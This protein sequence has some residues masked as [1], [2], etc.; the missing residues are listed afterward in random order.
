MQVRNLT[1]INFTDSLRIGFES[2]VDI[3]KTVHFLLNIRSLRITITATKRQLL[4][5]GSSGI[6]PFQKI[7][8]SLYLSLVSPARFISAIRNASKFTDQDRL[9]AIKK[10][11]RKSKSG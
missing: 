9:S 10:A 3:H 8:L 11:I 4:Y 2:A 5:S 7:L 6:E 1:Q